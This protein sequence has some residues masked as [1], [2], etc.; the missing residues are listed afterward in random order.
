ME[1]RQVICDKLLEVLVVTR[2]GSDITAIH[3]DEHRQVVSIVFSGSG[4][5]CCNVEGSSGC[6][7]IAA[8]M[9]MLGFGG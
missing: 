7:I 4:R 3:Y 1:N 9:K 5:K 8:V 6:A 2:G